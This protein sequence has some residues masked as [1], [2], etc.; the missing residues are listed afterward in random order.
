MFLLHRY[1][2]VDMQS[3]EAYEMAVQGFLGPEGKSPPILTGLRCIRF[4]PPNFTLGKLPVKTLSDVPFWCCYSGISLAMFCS[5][6]YSVWTKHRNT[7]A[8]WCTRW[9][10]SCAAR[11]SARESGAQETAPSPCRM[12]STAT[13]GR[14][15]MSRVPSDSTT[16]RGKTDSPVDQRLWLQTPEATRK[17]IATEKYI[18]VKEHEALTTSS[19]PQKHAPAKLRSSR[20]AIWQPRDY[21]VQEVAV[22][23]HLQM[24]KASLWWRNHIVVVLSIAARDILSKLR[25]AV[26]YQSKRTLTKADINDKNKKL[27]VIWSFYEAEFCNTNGN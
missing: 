9:D 24:T 22:C 26:A 23:Q 11:P 27:F 25:P 8:K 16:P 18:Q 17:N 1:A 3:Q 10:S 14:P 19:P 2:N 7:C 12:P 21:N 4:Q 15:L 5:Q 13:N 20:K 6:R